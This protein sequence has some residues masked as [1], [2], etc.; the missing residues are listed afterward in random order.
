[1]EF[2]G[3]DP[4]EGREVA[5]EISESG[6]KIMEIVGDMT[7]LVNSVDWLGSDYEAYV[8]DWNTFIGGPLANLVDALQEKS[9]ALEAH[10][11]QQENTSR[12]R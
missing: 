7:P 10:I 3:M 9:K 12:Q 5:A 6:Q 4:A 8:Q 1:M 11:D 2:Q